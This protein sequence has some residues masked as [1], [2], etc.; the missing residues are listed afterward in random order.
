MTQIAAYLNQEF[1]DTGDAFG[2]AKALGFDAV[3][4]PEMYFPPPEDEAG[5]ERFAKAL[6]KY[7]LKASWHTSPSHNRHFGSTDVALRERNIERML[8]ELDW[9]HR[10]GWDVFVIHPG[11]AETEAD[12]QRVYEALRLINERAAALDIQLVLENASG[13]FD[14]DPHELVRTC[15]E[16]S[17]LELALDCSH[18][19]R[20]VFCKEGRD[21]ILDHLSIVAPS[22]HSFQFNDYDGRTNCAVG[23]GM[24]PWQELMP[25]VLAIG[26]ETW[27]IEL[28]TIRETVASRDSLQGWLKNG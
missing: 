17:G 26:C 5:Q 28:H 4:I 22:I 14:G 15:G 8:W 12:R 16:V 6:E 25:R 2:T 11:P 1:F 23:K 24:L 9:I 21:T 18:A 27:T 19:Y 10:L 7:D 20:S 3:Q 13:A